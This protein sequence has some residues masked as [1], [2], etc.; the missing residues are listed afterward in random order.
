MFVGEYTNYIL[1]FLIMHCSY[2]N[3]LSVIS[4]QFVSKVVIIVLNS[5]LRIIKFQ[6]QAQSKLSEGNTI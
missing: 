2:R 5:S 3:I 6:S 4:N 1:M